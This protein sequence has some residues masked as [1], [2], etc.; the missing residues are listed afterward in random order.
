MLDEIEKLLCFL[1]NEY[2]D[3]VENERPINKINLRTKE[4]RDVINNNVIED[5]IFEYRSYMNDKIIEIS[6]HIDNLEIESKLE[7]RVKN[8]HSIYDKLAKYMQMKEEGKIPINKCLN[9]ILGIRIVL[10]NNIEFNILK[11]FIT[12]KFS[13][14]KCIDSTKNEY[15]ALHAYI[16][17]DNYS[18]PWEVQIW[19]FSDEK[20]NKG[21]HFK[22]KQEYTNWEDKNKG[23]EE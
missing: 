23:G 19:N 18:F 11:D 3:I 5:S 21:S 1:Q 7:C 4:V 14:I 12:K 6:Y 8:K 10:N 15:K 22:Y 20:S 9:D 2:I 13:N 17:R 16:K